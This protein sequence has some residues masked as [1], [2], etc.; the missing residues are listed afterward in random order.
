M[1]DLEKSGTPGIYRR[2]RK[3]CDAR[4]RCKC[5][6]V[7]TWRHRGKQYKETC[8]SFNE[9][10]QRKAAH[11]SGELEPRSKTKF[12]D[13]SPEWIE[14]YSGLT[15]RG[16]SETTRPEYRRPIAAYAMPVWKNRRLSDI[17]RGDVRRLFMSL[18]KQGKSTS[19]IK[20]L[21]VALSAL[22]ETAIEDDLIRH[23]P[24]KGVRIPAALTEEAEDDERAQALTRHELSALLAKMTPEW[25][26]FFEFL[27]HSG[28]RISEAI[29]L[30]WRHVDLDA[31]PRIRVREQVY[32]GKRK[33]LKT[34]K[35]RR[36][37]PLSAGMARRLRDLRESSGGL[38]RSPVFASSVGTTL[39][40]G[41]VAKN[42]LWPATAAA[43]L[44]LDGDEEESEPFPVTFHTFRH[45]CASLLFEH[46]RNIKQVQEWL[47]HADPGFTLRT[48]VH[49]MDAGVGDADF[50]DEAVAPD[51]DD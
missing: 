5:P 30:T 13:Y 40:P 46:G 26:L 18:R 4:D 47:G 49:L 43:G 19:V 31:E 36:D 15:S 9:A 16:F 21:R 23:N 32:R 44:V 17:E 42:L 25:R 10:R 35:A 7:I 22:F 50:F 3:D 6:W 28:L 45:T 2:H 34:R 11:E 12:G 39:I 51:A 41:K 29:G 1:A 14:S 24:A 33:K 27:T 48:Y 20:K 8:H 38:G 37:L